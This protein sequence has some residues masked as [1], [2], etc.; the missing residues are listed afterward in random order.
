MSDETSNVDQLKADERLKV[1][2][3]VEEEAVKA[4]TAGQPRDVTAELR[5]Y[6]HNNPGDC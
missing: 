3:P 4:D 1:E 2:V 5:G 6:C